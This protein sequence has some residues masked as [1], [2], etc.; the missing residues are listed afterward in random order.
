MAGALRQADANPALLRAVRGAR[1]LLP[2]DARFGD[3][4]STAGGRPEQILARHLTEMAQR[5]SATREAGLTA[6]QLWQALS[7]RTGR[8][9]GTEEVALLF[10]DLVGFSAWVLE[11]GD[12]AA[13]ELLRQVSAAVEPAIRDEGGR[14]VKR[15]GDGHMAVFPRAA[16]AVAA[17]L[18]MHDR[19]EEVEVEGHRPRLRAGVHAGRPRRLGGDYL[20]AD[21]NITARLAEAA[22]GGELLVSQVVLDHVDTAALEMR[23]KRRFKAKGAP[24]E[25]E[26]YAVRRAS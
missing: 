7:E 3:E 10:T 19:L 2:G 1:H 11:V 5:G 6:L 15:L 17:A 24:R 13:L 9:A 25:L 12:D 20:G 16:G 26:V 8:G 18:E 23:R 4:L 22:D 14:I 21:V